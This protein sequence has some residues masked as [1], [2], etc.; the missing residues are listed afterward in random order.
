MSIAYADAAATNKDDEVESK[1]V[2]ANDVD[3]EEAAVRARRWQ[4][5]YISETLAVA[6]ET[7]ESLSLF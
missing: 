5:Q 3:E 1:E 7:L 6:L 2:S 4:N